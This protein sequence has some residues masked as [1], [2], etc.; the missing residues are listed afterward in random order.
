MIRTHIAT[1]NTQLI[2]L[3]TFYLG[4]P[5]QDFIILYCTTIVVQPLFKNKNVTMY[6]S[7]LWI[8]YFI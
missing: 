6:V 3:V 8:S 4:W 1:V 7:T 5:S 2:R